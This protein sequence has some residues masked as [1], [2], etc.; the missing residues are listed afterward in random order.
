MTYSLICHSDPS[1]HHRCSLLKFENVT[2]LMDPAW[3]GISEDH[4]A[5]VDFWAQLISQTDIVILSQPTAESL[6]AYALLYAAFLAHFYSRIAVYATL[7][8][9]NLG[10]VTTLDLYTSQ[11]LI[12]P[13]DTNKLDLSDIEDAF[14][15]IISIKHSQILDL[16][17]KFEGL[18]I[19]A[20]NSG[21]A[22][23]GSIFSITTFSDKVIYA[24]RW[25]HTKDTILNSAAVLDISGK[26]LTSLM[27]PSAIVTSTSHLGSSLPYRKRASQFKEVLRGVL[28]KSGTAVIPCQVGGKFLDLLVLVNDMIY[29]QRRYRNQSDPP[30]FLVSYSRGR[31]L[32]YA[33]SMLEWLSAS[34]IK[35]WEGRNNRSP[36]DLGSRF[37]IVTPEELKKYSGPKVCF[38]SEVERLIDDVLSALGTSD[39][40]TV[41]LTEP[42]G[43]PERSNK[44]LSSMYTT[45]L[46]TIKNRDNRAQDIRPILFA[47]TVRAGFVTTEELKDEELKNFK[48]KLE[49]RSTDRAALMEKLKKEARADGSSNVAGLIDAVIEEED[50]DDDDDI[51]DFITAV[52]RKAN[53][54]AK[55]L[56]IPVDVYINP[57]AQ[58]RHKMFPFQPVK[59]KRD[60]YGDVVDFSQFVPSERLE[61]NEKR[62]ATDAFA[63]DEDPYEIEVTSKTSK[64]R[65]GANT[66]KGNG[67]KKEENMDDVSYLNALNK[68]HRRFLN[69][70]SL[71]LRCSVSVVDLTS[72]VDQR[73]MSVI[74]PALKPRNV[75]MVAPKK[76]QNVTALKMLRNKLVD[77]TELE[78]NIPTTFETLIRSLDVSVDPELDQRLK[79]QGVSDEYTIAHVVGRLVCDNA[80]FVDGMQHH[81]DKWVL[82]PITNGS[83]MYPKVSLAIGDVRLAE[84][85][86]RMT[87]KNHVAEFKGE[88]SL[89]IDGKVVVRKISDGE[90]VVDGSPS[91]LFYKVKAAVADMLA[92]V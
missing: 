33:R 42:D 29:E 43:V 88:G 5:A 49:K 30:I 32:T 24:P 59:I 71:S 4:D 64:K 92:K 18:T 22:P 20:Y 90:T 38:V 47:Q 17:S 35:T 79:W 34:V 61:E 26:P 68:P 91:E 77:V 23:G 40:T 44:I 52:N 37:S 12:G 60:D 27:R 14:D 46:K 56:E 28:S 78:F 51:P 66:A 74:W 15:H 72:L 39:K 55:P 57:E 70:V 76:D 7:P 1:G 50:D 75:L 48:V 45:W 31:S 10:R 89:V 58:P 83:K 6:G 36:F 25:N 2:I 41:V 81:R 62:S 87:E 3:D 8:V 13:V 11:G 86:R 80:S 16:K 9:A 82:K 54:T 21:Y 69:E 84:V 65:R 85:K 19:V 53:A 73:S 63:E 67:N